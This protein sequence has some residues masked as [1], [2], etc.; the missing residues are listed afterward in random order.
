MPSIGYFKG[1]DQ[2]IGFRPQL[3]LLTQ[4]GFY[5]LDPLGG[6]QGNEC[7]VEVVIGVVQGAWAFAMADFAVHAITIANKAIRT[8]LGL[9]H[10]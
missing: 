10:V 9:Q 7:V 2:T 5:E 1:I 4:R 3:T 8:R 6:D